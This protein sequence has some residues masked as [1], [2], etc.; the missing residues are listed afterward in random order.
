MNLEDLLREFLD[1]FHGPEATRACHGQNGRAL[2]K[3]FGSR[4]L[5]DFAG[6]AGG[7]LVSSYLVSERARAGRKGAIRYATIRS[8]LNTLRLALGHAVDRG[9]LPEM[10]MPWPIERP[11]AAGHKE[12]S[13][14]VLKEEAA[15]LHR[16]FVKPRISTKEKRCS[17]PPGVALPGQMTF[18]VVMAWVPPVMPTDPLR[19]ARTIEMHEANVRH[20]VAFYG[21]E[22][23]INEFEG[24]AGGR[25]LEDFVQRWHRACD[26]HLSPRTVKKLLTTVN[27]GLKLAKRRGLIDVLPEMPRL[28]METVPRDRVL[29]VAEFHRIVR[30]IVPKWRPWLM[31]A[32]FTAQKTSCVEAMTWGMVDLQ[33]GRFLRRTSVHT[34]RDQAEWMPMPRALRTFLREQI[35]AKQGQPDP[36]AV[37]V[38]RWHA[39][40]RALRNASFL[41]GMKPV[42]PVDLISTFEGWLDEAGASPQGIHRY[43]G[44]K[45]EPGRSRAYSGKVFLS[46]AAAHAVDCLNE[47]YARTMDTVSLALAAEERLP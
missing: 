21:S 36:S 19:T 35:E 1:A 10:P 15:E 33:Q 25:L 17:Y 23:P 30:A 22:R 16:R 32:L 13:R 45:T 28:R 12:A 37:L 8:R 38:G 39:V 4:P 47:H 3:V 26:G 24:K 40:R 43:R 2:K 14:Y 7:E 18:A 27:L 44:R 46:T 41:L 11:G 29:S 34:G 42:S 20:L 31:V 5:A 9:H 6:P